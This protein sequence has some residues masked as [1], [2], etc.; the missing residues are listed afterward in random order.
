MN[1]IMR[2]QQIAA[3]LQQQATSGITHIGDEPIERAIHRW[4][5]HATRLQ[6]VRG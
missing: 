6:Q 2:A 4:Q 5:Q 1:D 3:S